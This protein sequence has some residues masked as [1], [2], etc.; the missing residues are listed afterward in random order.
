MTQRPQGSNQ[1]K[2]GKE[3]LHCIALPSPE[4][5]APSC[6]TR[7]LHLVAMAP[8]ASSGSCSTDQ[9]QKIPGQTFSLK[10][11][12]PRW[13]LLAESRIRMVPTSNGPNLTMVGL[14]SFQLHDGVKALG[15]QCRPRSEP[16][17]FPG[18]Q[19]AYAVAA[20]L[21]PALSGAAPMSAGLCS[22]CFVG[23]FH[24]GLVFTSHHA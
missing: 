15:I 12:N 13:S 4:P 6:A 22:Q 5:S 20:A 19:I 16:H 23:M 1:K 8:S 3:G 18:S 14:M 24:L 2:Q 9:V 17:L 21:S 7:L 11:P 10:D